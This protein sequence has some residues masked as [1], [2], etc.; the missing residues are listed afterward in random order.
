[1][2]VIAACTEL[3]TGPRTRCRIRATLGPGRVAGPEEDEMGIKKAVFPVLAVVLLAACGGAQAAAGPEQLQPQAAFGLALE[4]QSERQPSSRV[5]ATIRVTT[6]GVDQVF[7]TSGVVDGA[8]GLAQLDVEVPDVGTVRQRLVGGAVYLALPQRPGTWFRLSIED[9]VGSGTGFG[10]NPSADVV[11]Q[12]RAA[13]QDVEV[14]GPSRVG[15]TATTH[16]SGSVDIAKSAA[17]LAGAVSEL[18]SRA[19]DAESTFDAHLDSDGL[20]R[21]VTTSTSFT[22]PGIPGRVTTETETVFTNYGVEVEVTAPPA[23]LVEDGSFLL[24]ALLAGPPG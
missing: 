1:M 18:A 10:G 7:R 4:D 9:V 13:A 14:V 22:T 6:T 5:E 23:E 21:K 12:L 20:V 15:G 2:I 17:A 19:Q 3:S 24:E 8:R 16:Y 11:E